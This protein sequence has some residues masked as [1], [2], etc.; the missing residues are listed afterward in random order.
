MSSRNLPSLRSGNEV[1]AGEILK[2]SRDLEL[3]RVDLRAEPSGIP[4]QFTHQLAAPIT[5]P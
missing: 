4:G 5:Y 1:R 2:V 3:S